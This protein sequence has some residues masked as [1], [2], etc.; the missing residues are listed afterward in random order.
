MIRTIRHMAALA[1]AAACWACT[2]KEEVFYSSRYDIVRV[3]ALVEQAAPEPGDGS[4][5]SPADDEALARLAAEVIAASPVAAGGSYALDFLRYDGGPL[6]VVATS[7]GEPIAGTFTKQ[8]GAATIRFAFGD[9]AYDAAVG[10]YSDDAGAP[11]TLLSVDL[12]EQFRERHP[13]L[14]IERVVRNEY[15]STPYR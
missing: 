14:A 9:C 8:P 3:E 7:G 2:E 11:R 6:T 10:S 1:L 4:D 12:T 5:A 15:T 13:D